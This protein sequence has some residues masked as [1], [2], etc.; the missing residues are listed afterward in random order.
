LGG[1]IEGALDD[2]RANNMMGER[3]R[4][5]QKVRESDGREAVVVRVVLGKEFDHGHYARIRC[6]SFPVA[7]YAENC[8]ME[9]VLRKRPGGACACLV[10]EMV[11]AMDCLAN[12]T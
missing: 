7:E 10:G 12:G 9:F 3:I 6:D 2:I 4:I 8:L 11:S 5:A 1:G